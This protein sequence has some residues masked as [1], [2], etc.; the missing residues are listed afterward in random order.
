MRRPMRDHAA[1]PPARRRQTVMADVA[2]LAGVSMQ[3]VSR[4]LNDNPRVHPQTR[5]RVQDAVRV[6]GYRRNRFARA[7]VTGRSGTLG[8]VCFD[9]ALH[10]PASTLFGIE[11]AAHVAGYFVSVAS[12]SSSDPGAVS[13]AVARLTV[14][15]VEGILVIAPRESAAHALRRVTPGVP[16]VATEAAARED[17]PLIGIDQAAGAR[18]AVEHL[19]ALGH[20]TVWHVSGPQDWLQ[21]QD[22]VCGWRGALA[23]AGRVEPPLLAGDWSARSGYELADQLGDASAVFVGND[24]MALGVLRRLHELR[25][26]IPE[27]IA[28]V[29]FDDIPEAAFF[30]PALTT[31]RQ[32][33]SELGRRALLVLLRQIE[34]DPRLGVRE[35]LVPELIVRAS[36]VARGPARAGRP[37]G[38]STGS[39]STA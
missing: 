5:E 30:A 34:G 38:G 3:T 19:L 10:G 8:V 22:R 37:S 23:A 36:T 7:L 18:A 1:T 39:S 4:V 12:L 13:D 31:I 33:F 24:Q 21:A 29:G 25:R 9:S 14:Q 35:R 6:L 27:D 20:S 16:I 11:Q 2:R 28:V 32:N 17:I 15:G 26:R